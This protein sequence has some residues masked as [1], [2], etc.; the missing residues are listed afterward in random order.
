MITCKNVRH[1]ASQAV[2]VSHI[3]PSLFQ[4]LNV[5][6]SNATFYVIEEDLVNMT[7]VFPTAPFVTGLLQ[8]VSNDVIRFL[9]ENGV[10]ASSVIFAAGETCFGQTE[11]VALGKQLEV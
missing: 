6:G 7:L 11:V 2:C 1:I 8:T 9:A 5:F 3:V 10:N 4:V